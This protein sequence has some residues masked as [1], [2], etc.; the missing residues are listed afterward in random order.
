MVF[1]HTWNN[2]VGARAKVDVPYS[3][4]EFTAKSGVDYVH[5]EGV[6]HFDDDDTEAVI[7][8]PIINQSEYEKNTIFNVSLSN[9]K[10]LTS[11]AD[12]VGNKLLSQHEMIIDLKGNKT[13]TVAIVENGFSTRFSD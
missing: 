5:T 9:P 1:T 13:P 2:F 7:I 4:D 12:R 10:T 3:T 11:E 8:V 6:L